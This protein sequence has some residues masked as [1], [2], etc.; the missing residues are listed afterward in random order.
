MNDKANESKGPAKGTGKNKVRRR[1]KNTNYAAL[2][3][4]AAVESG[5]I[6]TYLYAFGGNEEHA[7]K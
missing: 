7:R 2:T 1:R 3:S 5:A 6:I 4:T